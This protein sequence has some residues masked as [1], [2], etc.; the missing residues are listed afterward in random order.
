MISFIEKLEQPIGGD[1]D[2][3]AETFYRRQAES[4][5]RPNS[6]FAVVI[7]D[8][9]Q[10]HKKFP[11]KTAEDLSLSQDALD[12]L[13]PEL[14]DEIVKTAR[15]Y[16]EIA[17]RRLTK[18][19]SSDFSLDDAPATNVVYTGDIDKRAY[20]NKLADR[21]AERAKEASVGA[22]RFSAYDEPSVREIEGH[23]EAGLDAEPEEK[24]RL[25]RDLIKRASDLGVSLQS[26]EVLR[27][28]R[29]A[30]PATFKDEV[31]YRKMAA[32]AKLARYYDELAKEASQVGTEEG[33]TLVEVAECVR[34]LDKQA[35]FKRPGGLSKLG[36]TAPGAYEVV[37][38]REEV[39]GP[40]PVDT[41]KIAQHFGETFAR[42]YE[43]DA[44]VAEELSPSERQMLQQIVS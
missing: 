14:P 15:A 29:D 30:L 32:P 2:K 26:E 44:G 9:H 20:R 13:A 25:A 31:E 19:A 35:G 42:R 24:A 39:E 8:G 22:G 1:L 33:M 27:Y 7:Y 3:E 18:T 28:D 37:F 4:A 36:S 17:S 5:D 6:D 16:M 23:F 21:Q 40:E 11:V 12:R 41:E 10:T 38:P 34:L 43:S